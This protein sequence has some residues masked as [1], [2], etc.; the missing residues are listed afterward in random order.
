MVEVLLQ[1][2]RAAQVIPVFIELRRRYPTAIAFGSATERTLQIL[3]APLGLRWRAPLLARLAAEIGQRGGRLPRD[4]DELMTLPGVGHYVAGAALSLHG[5]TR[6]VV[7]DSNTVRLISRV[8][9]IE[10]GAETRREQ[11]ILN[12]FERLVPRI[13]HREFNYG[14]LDLAMT[15][16]RPRSPHCE[17]CPL[18][19]ICDWAESQNKLR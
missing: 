13:E 1:R 9:G 6:A 17:Y 15:V 3:I 16:C 18:V 5:E 14:L 8:R 4:L 7:I 10:Y 19:T 12:L 11:W 2:T